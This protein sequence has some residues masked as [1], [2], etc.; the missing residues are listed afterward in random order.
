MAS[1]A[2]FRCLPVF[3]CIGRCAG[4][5]PVAA[6]PRKRNTT[7]RI[8]PLRLGRTN[9]RGK[10]LPLP[11]NFRARWRGWNFSSHPRANLYKKGSPGVQKKKCCVSIAPHFF[12]LTLRPTSIRKVHLRVS[13][14]N[15]ADALR[16]TTVNG[17][18]I[19]V[20][21]YNGSSFPT[22]QR[23]SRVFCRLCQFLFQSP[24]SSFR[25]G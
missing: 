10:D 14:K 15:A 17:Q 5:G 3:C 4:L 7:E 25:Q 9:N 8:F 11:P 1:L 20:K 24:A 18:S 19:F 22:I 16:P 23:A 2:R 21:R 13:R 12:L 6:R